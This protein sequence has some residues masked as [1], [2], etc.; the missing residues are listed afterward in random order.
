MRKD[1]CE[2]CGRR[3]A[4]VGIWTNALLVVLKFFV[5][6]VSGS[7]GCIADGLHSASNIVTAFAIEV[8]RRVASKKEDDRYHYGY[9]KIEFVAAA[10]VTLLIGVAAIALISVSIKHLIQAPPVP[11]PHYSAMVMAVISILANEM[12]FRYMRCVGSQLKSQTIMANAW[13]NRADCFSSMAVLVGVLGAKMGFH[14]LDPIAAIVVVLIIVKI[15]VEIMI[16][17]VKSLLDISV[18]DTY[19]QEIKTILYDVEGVRAI[20]NLRTRQVGHQVW[21][22]VDICIDGQQTMGEAA[23]IAQRVK[24]TLLQEMK[25]LGRVMVNCRPMEE[26]A[27]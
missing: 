10:F 24:K 11:P 5:G 22:D 13:A 2:Q 1:K 3:V 21:V 17:A 6:Y 27:C 19:G 15:S 23:A 16:D 9:G 4:Q 20:S 25:D 7:K 8:S 18:N 12:M 14:Y 26:D